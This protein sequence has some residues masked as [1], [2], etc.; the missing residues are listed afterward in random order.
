VLTV[1]SGG[2][3]AALAREATNDGH[4]LVFVVRRRGRG[5]HAARLLG[6]CPIYSLLNYHP[7]ATGV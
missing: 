1:A 6:Y 5:N 7:L 3:G 2:I 4:D